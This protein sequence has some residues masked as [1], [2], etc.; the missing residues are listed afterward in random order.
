MTNI[1]NDN[2][3]DIHNPSSLPF[4]SFPIFQLLSSEVL[5]Q[6]F[7]LYHSILSLWI[8]IFISCPH[9]LSHLLSFIYISTLSEMNFSNFFRFTSFFVPS[10]QHQR[11]LLAFYLFLHI[12]CVTMTLISTKENIT[13]TVIRIGQWN[14]KYDNLF[15]I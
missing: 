2:Q 11:C 7:V 14:V 5:I 3:V 1:S 12:K 4:K 10:L 8:F 9:L 6:Y 15:S 13:P